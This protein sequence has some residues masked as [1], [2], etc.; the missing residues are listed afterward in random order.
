MLKKILS[1]IRFLDVLFIGQIAVI[2]LVVF[3]VLPRSAT[4]YL[5]A[6]LAGYA[7]W[8]PLDDALALFVRSIPLFVALPL[9]TTFDS[10]NSWRVL[11]LILFIRWLFI[12]RVS[13]RSIV[14]WAKSRPALILFVFLGICALGSVIP[15]PD[16]I[17]ALKRIA[18]FINLSLIGFIL[19]DRIGLS[20]AFARRVVRNIAIPTFLVIATGMAQLVMTY[21]GDIFSFVD[22]WVYR[23]QVT[24]FGGGWAAIALKT[25]T[26]FAYYGDQLSLRMFSLFPDSHS[27]PIFLLL[28]I[29]AVLAVCLAHLAPKAARLKDLVRTRARWF[30]V[31]VPFIF[32]GTLLSGTR[33]IW[34]ASI[35]VVLWSVLLR[36]VMRKQETTRK[37]IMLYL[38]LFTTVFFLLLPLAYAVFISD[39]FQ[40][41][42]SDAAL[43]R[44]RISSILDIG[45]TS[46]RERLRIWRVTLNSVGERP[47]LGVG[48]GN[49]PVV[50]DQ[51]VALAKAGSSAHNIYLHIAAEIGI[52][53]LAAALA[54]LW[55]LLAKTYEHFLRQRDGLLAFYQ[56]AAL[57]YVPWV[58]LYSLTDIAL[59]DERAFLLFVITSALLVSESHA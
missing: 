30:I 42:K 13:G 22:F 53:G 27:F 31:A 55:V 19:H 28:G 6:V 24:F 15:A 37:N 5:T 46:N 58:L 8:A 33:G 43:F 2:G 39:Q 32:L 25:N 36:W 54:A 51:D 20:R 23:I 38:S 49:F 7:L 44:K 9:T 14:S 1:S 57:L 18:Y 4:L 47:L 45:E 59:F 11:S 48:I 56:G 10:L 12:L 52:V 3:G 35:G 50:L 40:V 29:P 16:K 21:A 34:A 17:A 41:Q 26:W